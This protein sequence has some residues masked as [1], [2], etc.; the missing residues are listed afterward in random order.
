MSTAMMTISSSRRSAHRITALS[1]AEGVLLRRNRL[2]LLTAVALPAAMVYALK[3]APSAVDADR[4]GGAGAIL[5]T[6]LMA[7]TLLFAVYYNLVTAL[8]GRREQLV[9]KRLRTGETTDSEILAGTAAPAIAIAWAQI[10]VAAVAAVAV[11]GL[12]PPANPVLALVALVLGTAVFALLAAVSSAV[13]RTVEMAQ[14]TTLPVLIVPFA[15]SGLM[16]PLAMLP[17]PVRSV[18][19]AL[20][21][22]PVVELMR[23]GLT[24]TAADGHHL[25]LAASFG[26]ASV[27]VLVLAAWTAAGAWAARRWFRWEPRR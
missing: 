13:T 25:G 5:L 23:L 3:A 24:G 21:L 9:L 2:A 26:A 19:Q 22:T 12:A 15:L 8:V 14:V 17:E 4:P 16:F 10:A 11:F 6:G 1:R 7:F 18:A 20:P 27:P